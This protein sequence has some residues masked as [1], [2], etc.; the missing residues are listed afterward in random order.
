M[1]IDLDKLG[2]LGQGD[3]K[4]EKTLKRIVQY[5]YQ[6][7]E[8]LKYWQY[9]MEEENLSAVL[10]E[11]INQA[12]EPFINTESTSV[13]NTGITI[14]GKDG[15]LV[16][17]VGQNGGLT[18]KSVTTNS[19]TVN[20][21][22]L[23]VLLDAYFRSR[24][25]VSDTEPDAH[26]VVW[27][28]PQSGGSAL[29]RV[30]YT[31][32]GNNE[33]CQDSVRRQL[34][35]TREGTQ[36]AYGTQCRYGIY[37]RVKWG[38]E[39]GSIVHLKVDIIGRPQ[40]Q[41][42]HWSMNLIDEDRA[43]YVGA[44]EYYTVDTMSSMSEPMRNITYGDEIWLYVTIKFGGYVIRYQHYAPETF[45]VVAEGVGGNPD[46]SDCTVRYIF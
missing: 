15:S 24:I 20:G 46:V 29:S 16:M 40:D 13:T 25:I 10:R 30:E 41:D 42:V 45:R 34:T 22:E 1:N 8:Q 23:G 43:D 3:L 21:Q 4:D 27:V 26:G 35:F 36:P 33:S 5:L 44:N 19:L 9:N 12:S 17:T 28:Q 6:L 18:T 14:R 38:E 39:P 37:F 32:V 11:K 7:S 2:K 31:M